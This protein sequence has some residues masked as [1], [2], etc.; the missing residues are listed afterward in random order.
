MKHLQHNYGL[1][2]VA[3]GN[4]FKE[5]SDEQAQKTLEAAWNAGVRYYDTSPWYGLGLS[6]RRFGHFLHNK[7]R[8]EYQLS[9]KIGR[10]LTAT[11]N[12]PKTM[13]HNPSP[14]D[15]TYDYS[16]EATRRSVEDSLQRLGVESLDFVFIHDLSPD[17]DSEYKNGTTWEDHFEIAKNGAMPE[18]DKMK[19]EGLIKAWGLGVNTRAPILKSLE[20]AK[21]DVFLAAIQYS[22]LDHKDALDNLFP[23]IE[24]NNAELIIAAPFNSGLLTG[25]ERYNYAND[26]PAEIKTRLKKIKEVAEKHNV[27]LTAASLQFSL[28]PKCVGNVLAGASEPRQVEENKK[29]LEVKIPAEFWAD[30][31]DQNLIDTNAQTPK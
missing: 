1:G 20:V 21:P 3:I 11:K 26:I 29:A 24:K 18:L 7:K 12:P 22:L 31:K 19:E 13:W 8:E 25:S 6:E 17:H 14:F 28:A 10:I 30:L 27:N 15:Y 2:G 4:G 5:I 23:A 9:T 16:A